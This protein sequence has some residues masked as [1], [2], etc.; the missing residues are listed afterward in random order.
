M[1]TQP[2]TYY[3]QQEWADGVELI[4][5]GGLC[6]TA[7]FLGVH[8]HLHHTGSTPV[9]WPEESFVL[10]WSL[11]EE[12]FTSFMGLRHWDPY[13]GHAHVNNRHSLRTCSASYR[14]NLILATSIGL[15]ATV[16]LNTILNSWQFSGLRLLGTE[17]IGIRPHAGHW[18]WDS[19]P[20]D[21]A[22]SLSFVTWLWT[23]Q[24]AVL[25]SC[26]LTSMMI[27]GQP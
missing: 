15:E 9:C 13:H 27:V 22:P 7:V 10:S 3:I 8:Q 12:G 17:A 21:R 6:R 26:H 20:W 14:Q 11:V 19:D 4:L 18:T 25:S 2:F 16:Y 5:I 1:G 23:Q 24:S